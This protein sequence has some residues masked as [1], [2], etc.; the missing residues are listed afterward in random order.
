MAQANKNT[1]VFLSI[2][3]PLSPEQAGFKV[4]LIAAIKARGLI[5]RCVGARPED[6]DV[7]HARPIDQIR[8][9]IRECDG[10][11]VVA[12]EKHSA[13]KL[14][15]NSLVVPGRELLD[16]KLP[17]SWNQAEAAMAYLVDL[18]LLLISEDGLFGECLLE[19][20]V[21]GSVARVTINESAV[22]N[23]VFQRRM[24]SWAEDVAARKEKGRALSIEG[25][26][27][28]KITI[29]Q[30]LRILGELSWKSAFILGGGLVALLSLA[31]SL[32]AS[33]M[34]SK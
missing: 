5:P 9:I 18:P 13:D 3:R 7:P 25:W 11:V 28:E 4:A 21:V 12:Y 10:A 27:A 6:S 14:R 2:G 8:Q 30:I 23:E 20:G 15:L 31:Y 32:G 22:W 19:D 34:F 24:A 17:T 29:Q 1:N 33:H 26:D 16:A